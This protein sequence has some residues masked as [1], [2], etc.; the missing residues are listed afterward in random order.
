MC[1]LGFISW[2]RGVVLKSFIRFCSS[3]GII[4]NLSCFYYGRQ[5]AG[6]RVA[7]LRLWEQTHLSTFDNVSKHHVSTGAGGSVV[8]CLACHLRIQSS[9]PVASW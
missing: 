6:F 3:V 8:Q 4:V 7:W 1:K 5:A 2:G 9:I